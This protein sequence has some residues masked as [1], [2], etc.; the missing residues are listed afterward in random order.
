MVALLNFHCPARM[1]CSSSSAYT[2]RK[3]RLCGLCSRNNTAHA[4]ADKAVAINVGSVGALRRA[5]STRALTIA[6]SSAVAVAATPAI[7]VRTVISTF[8]SVLVFSVTTHL[9]GVPVGAPH[10]ADVVVCHIVSVG[11]HAPDRA[12]ECQGSRDRAQ[13]RD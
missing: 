11:R 5:A 7:R 10:G 9:L 13:Q 8:G 3:S 2:G 6:R 12:D 4:A 1:A